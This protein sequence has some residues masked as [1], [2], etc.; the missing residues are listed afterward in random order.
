MSW[1]RGQ[2]G[3]PPS[4]PCVR[5]PRTAGGWEG[6]RSC[7]SGEAPGSKGAA[8]L[9]PFS[10]WKLPAASPEDWPFPS[11]SWGGRRVGSDGA[12]PRG[13]LGGSTQRVL[14][15]FQPSWKPVLL[16]VGGGA[17][18]GA[19]SFLIRFWSLLRVP[20]ATTAGCVF[21]RDPNSLCWSHPAINVSIVAPL[22][23]RHVAAEESTARASRRKQIWEA[24]GEGGVAGILRRRREYLETQTVSS[25]HPRSWSIRGLRRG[26]FWVQESLSVLTGRHASLTNMNELKRP[27]PLWDRCHPLGD[28]ALRRW[29][30]LPL[31]RGTAFAR[32]GGERSPGLRSPTSPLF[33]FPCQGK[34]GVRLGGVRTRAWWRQQCLGAY[35]NNTATVSPNPAVFSSRS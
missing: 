9:R 25:F 22:C 24:G 33:P 31:S 30:S 10:R 11:P 3:D 12:S 1:G 28:W 20:G 26:R 6:A 21:S 19:V 8:T 32:V 4:S 35:A 18:R 7:A 13:K 15:G 23:S 2:E 27:R 16:R 29:N 17:G 14:L 5:H 34:A